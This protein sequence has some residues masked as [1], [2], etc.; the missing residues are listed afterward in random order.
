MLEELLIA[1]M[2]EVPTLEL[3]VIT[4]PINEFTDPGC[5]WTYRSHGEFATR[6][7]TRYRIVQLR[8]FDTQDVGFGFDE[9]EE[10]Y[11]DFDVHSKLLIVDDVFLSVGSATRTTA[12]S[13]TKASSTSP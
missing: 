6:F 8:A 4:K 10:R 9:T 1:R 5:E 7:P 12:A 2:T 11:T 13:C 3:V